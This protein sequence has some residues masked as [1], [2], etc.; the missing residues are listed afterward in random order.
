M[1]QRGEISDG[2]WQYFLGGG[3]SLE[4]DYADRPDVPWLSEFY[5]QTC[6]ELEDKLLCFKD[7]SKEITRTHIHIKLGRFQ[8]SINPEIWE[9]Y[10]SDLPPIWKSK[11]KKQ[12]I[13]GYW[14]ERLGTF[15][16]LI[17]IKSFMEEKVVLAATEFVIV[18]LGKQ[19]VENPPVDLANLYND[20]IPST[21]LVFILSTGSD[22]MAAFQRF[23]TDRGCLDRQ[24]K[25]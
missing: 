17:L 1:K 20:I 14:N 11:E 23:A 24:K 2:E 13:K 21:P 3:A 9:G 5:W 10:V 25:S 7:I 16:K 12:Q 19:F 22:P 15:Q 6:C 4:R 18:T 8:A